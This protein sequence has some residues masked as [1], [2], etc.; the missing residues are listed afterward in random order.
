MSY[1]F[2]KRTNFVDYS[3]EAGSQLKLTDL[4]KVVVLPAGTSSVCFTA[5]SVLKAKAVLDDSRSSSAEVLGSLRQLSCLLVS[6][7]DLEQTGVA[8]SVRKLRKSDHEEVQRIAS[9]L[10]EKW[11]KV[12]LAEKPVQEKTA[13]HRAP[14]QQT[15]QLQPSM[16]API[17]LT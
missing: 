10:I 2:R 12:V 6:K 14:L 4:K 8:F 9:N 3:D 13:E 1:N 7:S 11:K 15:L 5:E 16:D 17:V